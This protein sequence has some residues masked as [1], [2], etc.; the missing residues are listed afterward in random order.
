MIVCAAIDDEFLAL[1]IITNY[2]SRISDIKLAGTFTNPIEALPIFTDLS[3][4]LLFLD[5][6]MPQIT[7][8]DFLK[9]IKSPPLIIFTTAYSEFALDS[10]EADAVD[11][12][13]KPIPFTRFLTAIQKARNRLTTIKN[14][15]YPTNL[16]IKSEYKTIRVPVDEILFVEGKKDHTCI[17][18]STQ[19]VK[20]SMTITSLLEKL[21]STN[22]IRI[23]RSYIIALNKVDSI[24]RGNIIVGENKIPIGNQY[25][26]ELT[27][28]IS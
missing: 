2:S 8:L 16:F 7:G 26:D 24:D 12:L 14:L 20:T 18:T 22:F 3:I 15:Q 11:Y 10:Y 9:T 5:I 19:S 21:P 25:K 28:S 23:H 17:Q 27:K 1:E 4:D 13:V 6:D